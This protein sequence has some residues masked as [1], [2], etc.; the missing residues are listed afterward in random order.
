MLVPSPPEAG[1]T[2]IFAAILKS[3]KKDRRMGLD[4]MIACED[5]F[6]DREADLNGLFI[7]HI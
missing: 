1:K 6:M 3:S 2:P 7:F 5:D 4:R